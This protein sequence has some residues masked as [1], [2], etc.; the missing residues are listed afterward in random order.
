MPAEWEPHAGTWLAWPHNLDTWPGKFDPVPTIYVEMVRALSP[1]EQVHICINDA[2]MAETVRQL[3]SA[4][5]VDLRN[6]GHKKPREFL[7]CHGSRA[8]QVDRKDR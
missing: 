8:L 5:G 1:Y 6:G 7:R 4:S 2:K 3:L